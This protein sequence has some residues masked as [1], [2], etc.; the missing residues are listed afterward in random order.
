MYFKQS[1][2]KLMLLAVFRATVLVLKYFRSA[3]IMI[4]NSCW[5]NKFV[6]HTVV[7]SC[8]VSGIEDGSF[9]CSYASLWVTCFDTETRSTLLRNCVVAIFSSEF[10]DFS[11]GVLYILRGRSCFLSPAI[12]KFSLV[13][14]CEEG[15][16]GIKQQL[17]VCSISC[18]FKR[19]KSYALF[20]W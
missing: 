8:E 12:R 2:A 9:C 3:I 1:A 18:H 4:Y 6:P 11:K 17:T 16:L 5:R 15:G 19:V 10:V 13:T 14:Y 7:L 20:L